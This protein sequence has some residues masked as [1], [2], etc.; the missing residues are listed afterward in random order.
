MTRNKE[1]ERER[2]RRR[3]YRLRQRRRQVRR[4]KQFLAA[5]CFLLVILFLVTAAVQSHFQ[6]QAEETARMQAAREATKALS[7]PEATP[8]AESLSDENTIRLRAVGDNLIHEKLYQSGIQE[9]GTWNY[10]HLYAHVKDLISQADLAAVNQECI[11]VKDHEQ[12]SS[13]PAFGSPT[14]IGDALVTAGFDIVESA[15]NHTFDKGTS[16]ILDTID[17]WNTS[18]PDIALLGIHESQ[19]DADRISTLTCKGV[20]FSLLNYTTTINQEPYDQFPSYMIDLLRTEKVTE[21]VEKARSCSDMI[22]AFLHTGEEYSKE[23]NQEQ[24]NFL[25]LLL[26]QGVDIAICAHSHVLQGFETLRDDQGNEMLVYY[27]LGNFISTQ[28]EPECL[29]GGMADITITI[30]EKAGTPSVTDSQLIPLVT[31]Y[32]YDS[33]EYTVYPLDEYTE[34]LAESHSVHQESQDPFSLESLRQQYQA[35]CSQNSSTG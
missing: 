13:Y 35:V 3:Q 22:I 27:S 8:E 26:S 21:D 5:G 32:N 23:P 28:K 25:Q 6:A 16:A 24:M 29:L 15:T 33:Q 12:V 19:E 34:D 9:D 11:F 1:Q 4:Q 30:D 20:T 14:E 18:H 31:H 10:D 2:E 17:Y 7:T